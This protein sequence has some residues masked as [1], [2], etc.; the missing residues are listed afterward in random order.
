MVESMLLDFSAKYNTRNDLIWYNQPNHIYFT[1][2]DHWNKIFNISWK[3]DE[4]KAMLLF[5]KNINLY[6]IAFFITKH[7]QIPHNICADLL[8]QIYT[9]IIF[10]E[11][12]S[13]PKSLITIRNYNTK[14]CCSIWFYLNIQSYII[15][16]RRGSRVDVPCSAHLMSFQHILDHKYL[17]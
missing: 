3:L 10:M 16:A 15:V 17:Q 8:F 7:K 5:K 9:F 13:Q 1:K 14:I 11:V 2:I 12:Q 4:I 6:K